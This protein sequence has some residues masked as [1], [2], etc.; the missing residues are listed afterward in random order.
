MLIHPLELGDALVGHIVETF[1]WLVE[2]VIPKV[3]KYL[4]YDGDGMDLGPIIPV[5]SRTIISPL[6]IR[7]RANLLILL[8]D[9]QE[10]SAPASYHMMK[11][12]PSGS[13]PHATM[14]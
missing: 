2:H 3:H 5:H 11:T 9:E 6:L 4:S 13:L 7:A 12:S 8:T 1:M 10:L 14:A